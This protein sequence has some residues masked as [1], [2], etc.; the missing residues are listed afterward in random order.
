LSLSPSA[1]GAN[2]L[3]GYVSSLLLN[4]FALGIAGMQRKPSDLS[5]R[6][7][8]DVLR[9]YAEAWQKNWLL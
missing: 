6:E 5:R 9:S 8:Q 3:L 2:S 1:E 4:P 7:T